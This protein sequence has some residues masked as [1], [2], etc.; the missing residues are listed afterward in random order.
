M[1]RNPKLGLMA[2]F[3]GLAAQAAGT[4]LSTGADFLNVTPGARADGM[5]QAFCAVADDINTLSFNPAGLGNL[6]LPE[7]SFSQYQFVSD[8]SFNFA[9]AAVPLGGFGTLGLGYLGL[10]TS[11]FNSTLNPSA[12]SGTDSESALMLGWGDG[13]GIFQAGLTGKYIMRN[14]GSVSGTGLAADLGIRL[15]PVNGLSLGLAVLDLGPDVTLTQ[16]EALPTNVRLGVAWRALELPE[17]SVDLAFDG[18]IP[19]MTSLQPRYG[20]GLEYWFQDAFALRAGYL[21]NTDEEGFTAGAGVRFA[22]IELDYAYQP[23]NQLG[24]TSRF[25]GTYRFDTPWFAGGEVE[26][27]SLLSMANDSK[28]GAVITWKPPRESVDHYEV[29]I[30]SMDNGKARVFNNIPGPPVTM[31]RLKANTI[32]QASVV[33]V[34]KGGGRSLVSNTALL[35]TPPEGGVAAPAPKNMEVAATPLKGIVD[36]VGLKL[37]WDAVPAYPIKGYYI[38]RKLPS[39]GNM[40]VTDEPK[41]SGPLWLAN[42]LA[43]QGSE[44]TVTA[45]KAD[46]G[47]EET[48]GSYLFNPGSQDLQLLKAVPAV[49]LKVTA[50]EEGKAL[51]EWSHGAGDSLLLLAGPDHVYHLV[52]KLN[53]TLAQNRLKG[54]EK[55]NYFFIVVNTAADGSWTARSPEVSVSIP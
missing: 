4:G 24:S 25:S 48:V 49:T 6:R 35:Q 43:W 39:G 29:T 38:Y 31:K 32:Y 8:I 54:F 44:F 22:G 45:I 36:P 51:V 23:F 37:S 55:G 17:H 33:S 12:V 53:P 2:L 50:Q 1:N 20:G 18:E 28:G 40:K 30:T 19:L 41:K 34:G 9:G 3:F 47:K 21:V 5:G 7:V 42:P 15:R 26:A 11:P 14:V 16:Q 46:D 10:G 52:A 13:W 27:P